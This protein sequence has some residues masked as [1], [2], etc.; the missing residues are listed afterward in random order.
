[1]TD[2]VAYRGYV[3]ELTTV[4][5]ASATDDV[6]E[7]SGQELTQVQFRSLKTDDDSGTLNF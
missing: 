6:A 4:L 2:D 3:E 7:N 5:T 1:M